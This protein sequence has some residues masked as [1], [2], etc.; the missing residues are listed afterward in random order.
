MRLARGLAWGGIVGSCFFAF[1]LR[2][3]FAWAPFAVVGVLCLAFLIYA[4]RRE[5]HVDR[6][7]PASLERLAYRTDGTSVTF[8]WLWRRG[9]RQRLRILRSD[10]R[11]ARRPDDHAGDQLCVF[12]QVA[13]QFV[14]D[15]L[16]PR[17]NYHYTLFVQDDAGVWSDPVLQNVVT[18]S[19][20]DQAELEA[21]DDALGTPGSVSAEPI[22]Y[23]HYGVGSEVV[24]EV[25]GLATDAIFAVAGVF[26]RDKPAD[27]WQEIE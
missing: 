6:A 15:G 10:T 20:A 12:D 13:D 25:A 19:Q 26:A 23:G 8:A 11:C 14:D 4:G 21:S 1:L 5:K 3:G 2:S 16:R 24:D 18:L 27:G 17:R 22:R 7:L 9:H